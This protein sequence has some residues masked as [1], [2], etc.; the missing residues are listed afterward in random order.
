MAE[1]IGAVGDVSVVIDRADLAFGPLYLCAGATAG[2]LCD[3]ARL[4]WLDSVVVDTT[5]SEPVAVG[6]LSGVTGTVR[7]WMY[8]LGLSSQLTRETPFVLD[9]AKELGDASFALEGT[10]VV[11][12]V[13]VPF[14]AFVPIQQTEDTELG[15]PV[16]RK[17][18][19][20]SFYREIDGSE[21]SLLVRFDASTWVASVD[22][23]SFVTNETCTN[24]GPE[25]VCEGAVE[26]ACD[27]ETVLSSRDCASLNQ[28]C[29]AM[30]GCQD[31]VTIDEGS[32]AYRSLRN[33]LLSGTR[34][35]FTWD[36]KQ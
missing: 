22:F 11:A 24:E 31:R 19:S 3:T 26:H 36:Y 8:D 23:R 10:A 29:V 1:P 20:D 15:V 25:V 6:E 13:D 2:D 16:I 27:N 9:A 7:S 21:Q 30:V 5:R 14:Q 35:S 17:G 18:S 12:G 28:V 34:P 32:E 33:A 4:E